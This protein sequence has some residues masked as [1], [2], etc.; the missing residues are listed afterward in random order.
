MSMEAH[1]ADASSQTEQAQAL[2]SSRTVIH[3]ATNPGGAHAQEMPRNHLPN[4]HP[5]SEEAK[6]TQKALEGKENKPIITQ[7]CR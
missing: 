1:G 2:H 3:G 7:L 4:H 5:S 6:T